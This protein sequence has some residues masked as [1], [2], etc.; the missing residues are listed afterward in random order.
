[1]PELGRWCR[2]LDLSESMTAAVR[3]TLI[4]PRAWADRP[5]VGIGPYLRERRLA[6]GTTLSRAAAEIGLPLATL[7]HYES[8]RVEVPASVLSIMVERFAVGTVE[9]AALCDGA[10]AFLEWCDALVERPEVAEGAIS[11]A[12]YAVTPTEILDRGPAFVRLRTGLLRSCLRG[13]DWADRGRRASAFHA[14]WL[15]TGERRAEAA[16]ALVA[17]ERGIEAISAITRRYLGRAKTEELQGLAEKVEDR[18]TRAW[19]LAE[20]ALDL[21]ERRKG[22]DAKALVEKSKLLADETGAWVESWMR[23]RDATRVMLRLRDWASAQSQ[24]DEM[25]SLIAPELKGDGWYTR[26]ADVL[27]A[28]LLAKMATA[29]PAGA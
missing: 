4:A 15:A 11:K 23:R 26:Q 20:A 13:G 12:A 28:R 10:V 3:A 21:V 17:D 5:G 8:G 19:L 1:M 29:R 9:R 24:L 2:A 25:E 7:G 16:A 27:Q 18:A 22:S 14:H 6:T